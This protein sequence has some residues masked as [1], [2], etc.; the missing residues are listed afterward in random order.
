MPWLL[1][2]NEQFRPFDRRLSAKIVTTFADRE[3]SLGQRDESLGPK[4]RFS[5]LGNIF[6]DYLNTFSVIRTFNCRII[7]E[8]YIAKDQ[9][10]SGDDVTY[11]PDIWVYLMGQ[12]QIM[13][14]PRLNSRFGGGGPTSEPGTTQILRWCF[15]H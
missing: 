6:F 11:H 9:E 7:S 8:Y 4:S 13:R 1:S 14:T 2:A 10:G 3:V 12:R 15:D 5:R